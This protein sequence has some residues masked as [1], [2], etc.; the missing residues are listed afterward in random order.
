MAGGGR[1]LLLQVAHPLVAAGVANHSNYKSEPW[2]RL[3]RTMDT[4]LKISFGD[5]ETSEQASAQLHRRH[6]PVQGTTG[7]G[8]PYNAMNPDLLMWVW[9]TLVDSA[10]LV[11]GLAFE[12][13]T[14]QERE[15]LL[16]E[17]HLLAYACGVPEGTCPPTWADFSAY[18]NRVVAEELKVT[19]AARDVAASIADPKMLPRPIGP[20]AAKTGQALTAGM[21]PAALRD[22]YDLPWDQDQQRRYKRAIRNMRMAARLTPGPIRRAGATILSRPAKNKQRPSSPAGAPSASA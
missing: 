1:A 19:D 22:A 10:A 8:T 20:Y 9:A 21:L 13:L 2:Q 7:D 4:M 15:Q 17:Q 12:P 3:Y 16:V 11:Y 14:D 5:R 18:F 6:V